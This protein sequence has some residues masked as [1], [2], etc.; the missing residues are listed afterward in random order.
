MTDTSKPRRSHD[1][2]DIEHRLAAVTA[3]RDALRK[4]LDISIQ[5]HIAEQKLRVSVEAERDELRG[6]AICARAALG[7][8]GA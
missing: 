2:A 5:A 6:W 8:G 4:D 1:C 3:E 7:K